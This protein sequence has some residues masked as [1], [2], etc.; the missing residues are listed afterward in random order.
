MTTNNLLT[1][2]SNKIGQLIQDVD[3]DDDNE[4]NTIIRVGDGQD[5]K[6]FKA[7]SLILKAVSPHFRNLFKSENNFMR[8]GN[9]NYVEKPYISPLTFEIILKYMYTGS[10]S[11]RNL[12]SIKIMEII[13]TAKEFLLYELVEY[14]NRPRS[15]K[16]CGR[17]QLVGAGP[18][19]PHLLTQAACNAI[20]EADLVLADKLIPEEVL[21]LVPSD[22][23]LI[24]A[25]R[26]FC[27]NADAIQEEINQTILQAL[28]NGRHV[29]RLKQDPFL[30]GRG[31]EEFLFFKSH[32][33]IPNVIPGI[34]SCLSAPLYAN[35]PVTHRGVASQLLICTGTGRKN[36]LPDIPIYNSCRTTVFLMAIHRIKQLITDLINDGKYPPECPCAVI[37]KAS[38]K[39]Q[40]VIHGT[41]ATIADIINRAGTNPPGTLVVGW[42]CLTLSKD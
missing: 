29:V 13:E 18:G 34:S 16:K 1:T 33:Y 17:I 23:E 4:Y 42:T 15:N 31:G 8:D 12:D 10:I 22:T 6:L 9:W 38:C 41:L 37:E 21:K 30:F 24:V 25:T 26:K 39:D 27:A 40:R 11:I 28:N 7:H 2:F 3:N 36:S 14:L 5:T 19:N 35:I 20:Q 32:G